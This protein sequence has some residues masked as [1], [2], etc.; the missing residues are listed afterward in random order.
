MHV[1]KA[2]KQIFT[3]LRL[4]DFWEE[5]AFEKAILIQRLLKGASI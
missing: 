5:N 2:V 1:Y 3:R 4:E